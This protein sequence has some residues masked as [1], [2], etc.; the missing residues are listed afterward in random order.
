MAKNITK[1][2]ETLQVGLFGGVVD[3]SEVVERHQISLSSENPNGHTMTMKV[4]SAI[5]KHDKNLVIVFGVVD[6]KDSMLC[7]FTKHSEKYPSES[8]P[9]GQRLGNAVSRAAEWTTPTKTYDDVVAWL[10][11][12]DCTLVIAHSD[13]GRLFTVDC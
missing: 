11:A 1:Q 7:L 6:K 13:K 3:S 10:S 5:V 9:N 8:L 12:N 4:E 2:K